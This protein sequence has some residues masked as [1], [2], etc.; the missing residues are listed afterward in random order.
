MLHHSHQ[1]W[2]ECVNQVCQIMMKGMLMDFE[3]GITGLAVTGASITVGGLVIVVVAEIHLWGPNLLVWKMGR[4]RQVGGSVGKQVQMK[5]TVMNG[6]I[7]S[8]V[9]LNIIC[10][11][12][13]EEQ[14]THHSCHHQTHH[15][16]QVACT[17]LIQVLSHPSDQ[18]LSHLWTLVNHVRTLFLCSC[19]ETNLVIVHM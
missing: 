6:P 7:H 3:A 17:Q 14:P 12:E 4:Q 2:K 11:Q 15:F 16:C 13:K 1:Q 18:A 5:H 19:S 10:V 8:T 9:F